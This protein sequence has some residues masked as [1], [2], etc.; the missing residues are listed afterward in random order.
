MKAKGAI[1]DAGPRKF[2]ARIAPIQDEVAKD[3]K[4]TDVLLIVRKHAH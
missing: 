4:A 1:V 2:A 3:L